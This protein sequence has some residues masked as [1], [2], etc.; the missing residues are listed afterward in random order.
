MKKRI[1]LLTVIFLLITG[2]I[3]CD[4]KDKKEHDDTTKPAA[5]NEVSKDKS[6]KKVEITLAIWDKNQEAGIQ[7]VLDKFNEEHSNI[8][9]SLEVTP[10]N[11]YWTKLDVAA[12]AGLT[13]DAFWMNIYLPKYIKGDVL[14]PLD[15]YIKRDNIDMTNYIE[16]ISKIYNYDGKQW[17]M[18]KG[19]D[20]V[21]VAYNKELFDK[22]GV[23]YPQE[24][25]TY[26]DMLEKANKLKKA[27]D[28]DGSGTY[29]IAVSPTNFQS[30]YYNFIL[31]NKGEIISDDSTESGFNKPG[32]VKG[33][34]RILELLKSGLSAPYTT[35]SSPDTGT[36][37]LYYSGKVAMAYMGSWSTSVLES[38]DL[39]KAGNVGIVQM[40]TQDGV[41]TSIMN[42]LGYCISS[43][44][45]HQ[46]ETWELIKFLT[47]E[48]GNEVQATEGIDIPAMKSAQPLYQNAFKNIDIMPIINATK[49]GHQFP[50]GNCV[51]EW[52]PI[53]IDY[54]AQIFG[55]IISPKEGCDAIYKEMQEI[56]DKNNK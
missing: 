53:I 32:T 15:E 54:T 7:K 56:I 29:A 5:S 38:C 17:A 22:Y 46:D 33:Y 28:A 51:A 45:E 55:E 8:Q 14:I 11:N 27:M 39:A 6:D 21:F 47:S 30:G 42:G 12:G 37:A 36:D 41:N 23:E 9:A 3:G 20:S 25:W 43:L 40:P 34:E 50:T 18:P 35:L 2:V 26:E 10:W 4:Q 16:P 13:A 1:A 49:T 24:G 31:Q 52:T 19:V 44:S 48:Y